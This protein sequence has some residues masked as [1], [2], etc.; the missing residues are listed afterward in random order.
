MTCYF[1]TEP[2][3]PGDVNMHHPVY[4]SQ[5]GT[6]T[7]PAHGSCH[8]AF[9]SNQNDYREFGRR[10]GEQ[11]ALTRRWSLNLLNVKTDPRHDINRSFYRAMYA[12]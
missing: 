3:A 5:G 6:H 4:R 12:R 2:I 1:C 7:E 9:H 11:S 8:R 10:G